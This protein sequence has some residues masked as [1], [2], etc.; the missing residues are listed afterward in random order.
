MVLSP[1]GCSAVLMPPT[2]NAVVYPKNTAR[3]DQRLLFCALRLAAIIATLGFAL[4][5]LTQR[6]FAQALAFGYYPET[7]SPTVFTYVAQHPFPNG[8]VNQ[9]LIGPSPGDWAWTGNAVEVEG[10]LYDKLTVGGSLQHLVPP[11][12][13]AGNP[14]SGL[15]T[16]PQITAKTYPGTAPH[17]LG[18]LGQAVDYAAAG[19]TDCYTETLNFFVTKGATISSYEHMTT[20]IFVNKRNQDS[21]SQVCNTVPGWTGSAT[22]SAEVP[23]VSTNAYAAVAVFVDST[24]GDYNLSLSALGITTS[25]VTTVQLAVGTPPNGTVINTVSGSSFLS[26]VESDGSGSEGTAGILSGTSRLAFSLTSYP[27]SYTSTLI[28]RVILPALFWLKLISQSCMPE[29]YPPPPCHS[30]PPL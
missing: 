2:K 13:A 1:L 23:P 8:D 12:G 28:R 5:G 6:S 10:T 21:P 3:T 30:G 14:N 25:D 17:S 16:W 18:A 4:C 9:G 27:G 24:T 15:Y 26:D 22:G 11:N 7:P 19:G 20:G 29:P